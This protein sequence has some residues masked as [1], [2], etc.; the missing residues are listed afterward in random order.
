MA[1]VPKLTSYA[2]VVLAAVAATSVD[3]RRQLATTASAS[4][5]ASSIKAGVSQLISAYYEPSIGYFGDPDYANCY[6]LPDMCHFWASNE[7]LHA[8]ALYAAATGDA[9]TALPVIENSFD[10][11]QN[12]YF[13]YPYYF[14][15]QLTGI[16]A[17]IGAY[18]ATNS[19]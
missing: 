19:T 1:G 5:A 12:Q 15:D 2:A 13:Q 7:A 3:G 9:A 14:G 10:K 11:L 4:D 18:D 6:S 17:W 16:H 8:L